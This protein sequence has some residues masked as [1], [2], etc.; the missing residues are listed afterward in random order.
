[1][2]KEPINQASQT[3]RT[4]QWHRGFL[5]QLIIPPRLL[6]AYL[7]NINGGEILL[8]IK[9]VSFFLYVRNKSMVTY[10]YS[11]QFSKPD[12]FVWHV[13]ELIIKIIKDKETPSLPR[14]Q[15]FRSH[16]LFGFVVMTDT[17]L[18]AQ[19]MVTGGGWSIP[20]LCLQS[21]PMAC[22]EVS[23]KG[24]F[25]WEDPEQWSSLQRTAYFHRNRCKRKPELTNIAF[26]LY[27]SGVFVLFQNQYP[28]Q[29]PYCPTAPS[30]PPTWPSGWE[31]RMGF[32][33]AFSSKALCTLFCAWES[34][35]Q[36]QSGPR[37]AALLYWE[38][39]ASAGT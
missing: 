2:G 5:R 35:G 12:Y 8:W 18:Q 20:S 29:C 23:Q 28:R 33:T 11:G 34:W 4:R 27:S 39:V 38:G 30:P 7:F 14:E 26:L 10:T 3:S 13:K 25:Q 17:W 9:I 15:H 22:M 31:K 37:M 24:S 32:V 21:C 6:K 36:W 1:M 16:G 19:G